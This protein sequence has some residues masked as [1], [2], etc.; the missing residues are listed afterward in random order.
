[1][2]CE[3]CGAE[4][5]H[6]ITIVVEG[7]RMNVCQRCASHGTIVHGTRGD[8]TQIRKHSRYKKEDDFD[9]VSG[10]GTIIREARQKH[11]WKQEE[12]AHKVNEPE[13][14]IAHLELGKM[15]PPKKIAQKLEKALGI[16]LI[17]QGTEAEKVKLDRSPYKAI[18]LGDVVKIRKR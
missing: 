16:S 1:M 17:E 4:V 5:K 9:I 3:I 10:Y 15:T 11:G 7:T 6:P 14:T 18:T 12:L 13:S 2:E 8:T